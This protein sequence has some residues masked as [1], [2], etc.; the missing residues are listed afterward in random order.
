MRRRGV[1]P[2]PD[3]VGAGLLEASGLGGEAPLELAR[4]LPEE[5]VLVDIPPAEP[6]GAEGGSRV[7]RR[8]EALP[9]LDH[10]LDGV[11]VHPAVGD[12][13]AAAGAGDVNEIL[14][15]RQR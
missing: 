3:P 9:P 4:L 13:A 5:A 11:L 1:E 2:R 12:L 14:E 15:T 7:A 10:V 6:D 8:D